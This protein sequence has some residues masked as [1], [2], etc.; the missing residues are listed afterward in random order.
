[1]A[2]LVFGRVPKERA[3][4]RKRGENY[5]YNVRIPG[6]LMDRIEDA[7]A[8]DGT[9]NFSQ[10]ALSALTAKCCEVEVKIA[11]AKKAGE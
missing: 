6:D 11:L 9:R 7:M 2:F 3:T 4:A 1:M 5:Q 10:F 8:F